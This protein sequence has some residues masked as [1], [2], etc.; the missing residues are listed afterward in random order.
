[1]ILVTGPLDK[2]TVAEAIEHVKRSDINEWAAKEIG[3]S[4]QSQRR[5]IKKIIAN[6]ARKKTRT[7]K[8]GQKVSGILQRIAA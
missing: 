8:V 4:V 1:M 3:Q 6:L 5:Q 7:I 2:K